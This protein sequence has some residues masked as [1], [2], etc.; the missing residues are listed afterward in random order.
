[1]HES[2]LLCDQGRH[3]NRAL[4]DRV[5][6]SRPGSRDQE[7]PMTHFL[8]RVV[9]DGRTVSSTAGLNLIPS[10]GPLGG[11]RF[12]MLHFDNVSLKGAARLVVE[13]GYGTDVFTA[14]SGPSFWSRPVDTRI[15]PIPIRITGGSGS[16][17]LLEYGSG[18]P[19]VTP[20]FPPGTSTGSRSNCDPFLHTNPYDEP[21]YETRLECN[22]GF[23]WQNAVCS[24]ATIPAAVKDRVKAATGIIVEV[25]EGHVSSCSGTLI[26]ADLFLTARHCLTDPSGED[27]R[28][29]SVSFDYGTDACD[30]TS[31]PGHVTRFF[32]VIEE[33]AAGGAPSSF[34]TATDW[35]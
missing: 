1:M 34:T 2:I 27:V 30:G 23:A 17:R 8:G 24:L 11:P 5:Q 33:V 14:S 26:A 16:A 4:F 15:S 20:G 25:H 12:V 19:S 32:K 31:P 6:K 21:I 28:S 10:P 13:L 3:F 7:L 9:Q 18:E 29:A 35:V 22:P